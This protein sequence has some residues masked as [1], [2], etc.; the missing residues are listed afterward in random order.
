M[1]LLQ[2]GTGFIKVEKTDGKC[3]ILA[4]DSDTSFHGSC[5]SNPA[6]NDWI[7]TFDNMVHKFVCFMCNFIFFFL[8]KK[9][10]T[11]FFKPKISRLV[12]T[13]MRM[14]F[15]FLLGNTCFRQAKEERQL[16]RED[17]LPLSSIKDLVIVAYPI[18]IS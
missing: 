1:H 7:P 16:G 3:F 17:G 12:F 11:Y 8:K 6:T 14:N 18:V 2:T 15:S 4:P 9:I 5:Q 10:E 13:I